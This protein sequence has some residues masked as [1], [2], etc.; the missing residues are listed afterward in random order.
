MY[1]NVVYQ[2]AI[3]KIPKRAPEQNATISVING[4]LITEV[5]FS[6]WK[7]ST[8]TPLELKS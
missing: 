7:V 4:K 1:N 2:S 3:S 5:F 8:N 6:K